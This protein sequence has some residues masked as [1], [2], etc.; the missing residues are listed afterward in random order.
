MRD[1]AVAGCR[2]LVVQEIIFND[3][4]LVPK[5]KNEI[6]MAVLAIVLHDMPQNRL[7]SN[8]HHR[9]WDALRVFANTGAQPPAEQ[10]HF[11]DAGSRRSI[12]LGPPK[13]SARTSGTMVIGAPYLQ[14]A[15]PMRTMRPWSTPQSIPK[16]N[17]F[18]TMD[19]PRGFRWP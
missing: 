9:F 10:N 13:R 8:R 15:S 11:H 6:P 18:A 3:V 12:T 5:A 19:R 17:H 14:R 4:S 16:T 7:V 2:L 1:H